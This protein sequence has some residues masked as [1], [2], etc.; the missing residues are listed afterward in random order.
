MKAFSVG[1]VNVLQKGTR[2]IRKLA[3]VLVLASVFSTSINAQSVRPSLDLKLDG[4]KTVN[5]GGDS[6]KI[7]GPFAKVPTAKAGW[8]LAA[9]RTGCASLRTS[10]RR[11]RHDHHDVYDQAHQTGQRTC[12]AGLF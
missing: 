6:L 9:D 7:A 8:P 1:K 5:V 10:S 4:P 2:M 3:L 12:F 11:N